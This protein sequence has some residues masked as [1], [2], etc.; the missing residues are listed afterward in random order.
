MHPI[1]DD[2]ADPKAAHLAG[3][4]GDDSMLIIEHHTEAAIR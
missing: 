3:R 2:R 4:V 1:S